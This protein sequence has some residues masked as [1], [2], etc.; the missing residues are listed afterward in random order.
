MT[1]RC[2][3]SST[4]STR[5]SN[6]QKYRTKTKKRLVV[7]RQATRRGVA[8]LDDVAGEGEVGAVAGDLEGLEQQERRAERARVERVVRH[9]SPRPGPRLLQDLRGAGS[10][11]GNQPNTLRAR[12]RHPNPNPNR[13]TRMPNLVL[14]PERGAEEPFGEAGVRERQQAAAAVG[15][16]GDEVREVVGEVAVRHARHAV[17][18]GGARG[19]GRRRR[20]QLAARGGLE[21]RRRRVSPPLLVP[22]TTVSHGRRGWG[23]V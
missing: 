21:R 7:L 1:P 15:G 23:F 16:L 8:L 10:G 4:G 6:Q 5:L 17:T 14:D 18:L 22:T 11:R 13:G 12:A 9:L 20:R 19:G 2:I 3:N